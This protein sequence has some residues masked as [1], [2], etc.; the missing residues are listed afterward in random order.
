MYDG[1]VESITAKQCEGRCLSNQELQSVTVGGATYSARCLGFSWYYHSKYPACVLCDTHSLE[2][3]NFQN[4]GGWSFYELGGPGT[5]T[6]D[7]VEVELQASATLSASASSSSGGPEKAIDGSSET[8]WNAG[9]SA[10]E[11]WLELAWTSPKTISYVEFEI[12]QTPLGITKW[13]FW[14]DGT[15][16]HGYRQRTTSG[17]KL[18]Y[19]FQTPQQ[20]TKLRIQRDTVE[21]GGSWCA[22]REVKVL[23]Y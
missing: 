22:I 19:F 18:P 3:E 16:L 1:R 15:K 6:P 23:G 14:A 8:A 13:T 5:P 10:D 21:E 4:N 7:V 2:G 11:S 9:T 17:N 12:E 20:M